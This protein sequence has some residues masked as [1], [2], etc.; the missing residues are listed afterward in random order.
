MD[1][2]GMWETIQRARALHG[3]CPAM[4][5]LFMAEVEI[6]MTVFLQRAETLRAV[7]EAAGVPLPV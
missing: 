1:E 6:K 3:C 7:R 5:N 4:L 2:A